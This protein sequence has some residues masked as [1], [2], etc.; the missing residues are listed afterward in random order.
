MLIL[1]HVLYINALGDE[2]HGKLSNH[3]YCHKRWTFGEWRVSL[4]FPLIVDI[5]IVTSPPTFTHFYQQARVNVRRVS[6]L[7]DPSLKFQ[8]W[9]WGQQTNSKLTFLKDYKPLKRL[10]TTQVVH[11]WVGT[12]FQWPNNPTAP[13]R[14]HACVYEYITAP[15]SLRPCGYDPKTP[16]LSMQFW[17][18]CHLFR[19]ASRPLPKIACNFQ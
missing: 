16:V 5:G 10:Q 13:I 18:L 11:P 7:Y 6:L 1:Y 14:L 4:H 8:L 9:K 12:S 19:L 2:Y 17:D 15:I 3:T